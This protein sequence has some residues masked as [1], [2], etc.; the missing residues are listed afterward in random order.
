VSSTT[1]IPQDEGEFTPREAEAL[2]D[3]S[4]DTENQALDPEKAKNALRLVT[5]IVAEHSELMTSLHRRWRAIDYMLQGNTLE[6][7]GPEDVHVPEIYKAMETMIPRIEEIIL[8]K[9]PWF[10]IVPRRYTNRAEADANSAYLDWEFDQA[11]IRDLIQPSLRDMLVSQASAWYIW[12]ETKTSMRQAREITTV[13]DDSGKPSR[14]LK[15]GKRKEFVDY[16]GPKAKLVDPFDLMIDPKSTNPQDALYCGHRVWL[17]IDEI[18]RLGKKRGWANLDELDAGKATTLGNEQDQYSWTRDPTTRFSGNRDRTPKNDGRPDPIEVVFLNCLYSINDDDTYE[19][20]CFVVAGG[21]TVLDLRP[22]PLDGQYRPYATMRVAKTGHN[23]YSTGVFDNAVRLNQHIDRLHQIFLRGAAIAGCPIGFADGEGE[24]PDNL[25]RVTPGKIYP[26]VANIRFT[27]IPDGFLRSLPLA[28]SMLTRNLEEVVGAFRIQMGQ[29]DGG[30]ATEATLSLQEGNRRTR[31][32]IRS[33]GDGLEQI[34][35]IFQK[36]NLQFSP[37]DVEFPV[38]GK[39]ALDMRKTHLV[40]SPADLLD[41]VKFELVGL[42]SLRTYGMKATGL[43]AVMNS[44]M[45][46]IAGNPGAIDQV[47]ILYELFREFVGVQEADRLVKMPTPPDRLRSQEEEN[48]GL[49]AGEEIEVDE[50]DDHKDHRKKMRFLVERALDPDD[51][52]PPHVRGVVLAHDQTHE[53][54]KQHQEAKERAEQRRKPQG[55]SMAPPEAG[56]QSAESGRSSPPPGG[57]S[58]ALQDLADGGGPG[59]QTAGEN[60]GPSDSRKYGRSG[61]AGR[62]TNQSDNEL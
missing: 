19:D 23:F 58:N 59:G 49:I 2:Y 40:M 5:G 25:Y 62:T 54:M 55:P 15:R 34:L 28:I 10:R 51:L 44:G 8:E 13:Y 32:I 33:V 11:K 52:M 35:T 60:P 43:Q 61:R 56:G 7:G 27:S 24:L 41:D 31:G 17:T 50:D 16:N 30:T 29:Q 26:G 12:W 9:D 45:P 4:I 3:A 48:E 39:R 18:R 22:N 36:L 46:L 21:K 53:R 38:L 37:S 42:A 1:T 6:K 14:K 47:G 20:V 57:M